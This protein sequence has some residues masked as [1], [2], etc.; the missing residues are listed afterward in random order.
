MKDERIDFDALL[1]D[2]RAGGADR[3]VDSVMAAVMTRPAPRADFAAAVRRVAGPALV[4][5]ALAVTLVRLVPS[6]AGP[7]SR[8]APTVG[9]ALGIPAAADRAIRGSQPV[10]ARQLL[11]ALE[12][13]P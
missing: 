12:G 3:F 7:A 9:T 8:P 2:A 10:T 11:A 5:A 4:I 1:G 13:E 6:G